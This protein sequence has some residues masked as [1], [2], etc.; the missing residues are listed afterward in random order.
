MSPDSI[1]MLRSTITR[2]GRTSSGG[3]SI[4]FSS[5]F[6][7]RNPPTI[8]VL[9]ICSILYLSSGIELS[10]T[11][12]IT[13]GTD[14]SIYRDTKAIQQHNPCFS[15]HLSFSPPPNSPALF[16]GEGRGHLTSFPAW[17]KPFPATFALVTALWKITYIPP[18]GTALFCQD[19]FLFVC[20]LGFFVFLFFKEGHFPHFSLQLKWRQGQAIYVWL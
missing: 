14:M 17:Q 9:K 18:K 16:S 2:R 6:Q 4:F 1:R 13:L 11:T 3:T 19:F 10:D 7:K 15:Q 8:T 5:P 20:L 12:C